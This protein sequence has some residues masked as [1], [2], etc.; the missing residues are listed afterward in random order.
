M[1]FNATIG[2]YKLDRIHPIKQLAETE[3]MGSGF[4]VK[5]QGRVSLIDEVRPSNGQATYR[6]NHSIDKITRQ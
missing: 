5:C 6:V 3:F 2:L 4:I 1:I